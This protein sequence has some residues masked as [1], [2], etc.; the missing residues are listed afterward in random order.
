MTIQFNP[1]NNG[2]L[3]HST[4]QRIRY[5]I[6]VVVDRILCGQRYTYRT[7]CVLTATLMCFG[8][9]LA[10]VFLLLSSLHE[11]TYPNQEE[12]SHKTTLQLYP[13]LILGALFVCLLFNRIIYRCQP[14]PPREEDYLEF[15]C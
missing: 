11:L 10:V 14:H 5:K 8:L 2:T 1:A 7:H 12:E 9:G 13:G 3:T 15:N 4:P 6:S